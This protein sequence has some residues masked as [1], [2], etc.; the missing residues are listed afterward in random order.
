MSSVYPTRNL[1]VTILGNTE[2]GTW[3][4]AREIQEM[5]K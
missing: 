3:D 4:I 2:F 5:I 1:Q